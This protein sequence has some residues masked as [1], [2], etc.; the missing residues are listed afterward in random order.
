MVFSIPPLLYLTAFA[1]LNRYELLSPL[2]FEKVKSDYLERL[3]KHAGEIVLRY[4][5]LLKQL[6]VPRSAWLYHP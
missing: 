6:N 5:E 4:I 3:E 2:D 1:Q